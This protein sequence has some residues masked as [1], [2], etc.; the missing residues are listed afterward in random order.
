MAKLIIDNSPQ[1]T[2]GWFKARA[3]KISAS[4]ISKILTPKKL[5][6]S[7]SSK[8]YLYTKAIERIVNN[9]DF[10]P[11]TF[12]LR[13]GSELESVIR[14][15]YAKLNNIRIDEIGF[16]YI[17]DEG[18]GC[19]V[20]GVHFGTFGDIEW[21][22]EIKRVKYASFADIALTNKPLDA[23]NLQQ[24]F[25][26]LVMGTSKS[27]Y[28]AMNE[29]AGLISLEVKRDEEII[30]KIK[31]AIKSANKAIDEVKDKLLASDVTFFDE[32][33]RIIYEG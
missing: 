9:S 3:G 7:K 19:S 30:G 6:P 26:M 13:R 23:H 5:E 29:D 32:S 8:E 20:D 15:K 22:Y 28:I 16:A 25:Q 12:G 27:I 33:E 21:T 24:Q 1:N 2:E 18:Y 14:D 11:T 10:S 17:E 4:E 31:K